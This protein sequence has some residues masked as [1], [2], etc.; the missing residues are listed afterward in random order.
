MVWLRCR[1][2]EMVSQWHPEALKEHLCIS[3]EENDDVEQAVQTNH[4]L[5]PQYLK[6]P[7]FTYSWTICLCLVRCFFKLMPLNT[8][9]EI[10]LAF[11]NLVIAF[12]IHCLLHTRLSLW[13]LWANAKQQ[14][15]IFDGFLGVHMQNSTRKWALWCCGPKRCLKKETVGGPSY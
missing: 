7:W 10:G 9:E 15:W 12:G 4:A 11:N 2:M 6:A 3:M 8:E 1:V 14:S 13:F 5:C